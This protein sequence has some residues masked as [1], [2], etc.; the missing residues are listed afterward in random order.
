MNNKIK[1]DNK[2]N[3]DIYIKKIKMKKKDKN[4]TYFVVEEEQSC[5]HPFDSSCPPQRGSLY[6]ARFSE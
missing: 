2:D 3:K 4:N 6:L 5:Q 1:K